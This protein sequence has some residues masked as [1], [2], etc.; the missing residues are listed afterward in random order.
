[1]SKAQTTAETIRAK[2][3]EAKREAAE[4]EVPLLDQAKTL[5]EEIAARAAELD[6]I[7]PQLLTDFVPIH[8]TALVNDAAR[9]AKAV[10]TARAHHAAVLATEA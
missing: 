2:Q 7:G 5:I 10:E 8:F 3:E 1:M 9:A 4:H 6:A